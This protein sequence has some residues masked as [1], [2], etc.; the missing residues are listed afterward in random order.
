M[1][2]ATGPLRRIRSAMLVLSI[3][4]LSAGRLAAAPVDLRDPTSRRIQVEFEISPPDQPGRLN[5]FWSPVRV[6]YLRT[7]PERRTVEIRIPAVEIEAHLRSTGTDAVPG[8]FSDFRWVLD[9]ETGEVVRAT[10]S[11][12]IREHLVLGPIRSSALVDIFVDMTTRTDSGYRPARGLLGRETHLHCVPSR[13]SDRCTAV[14]PIPYDPTDGYV[15]AV[16]SLLVATPIIRVRAFSP[17]GEARFSEGPNARRT[18]NPP[19]T[20]PSEETSIRI[21]SGISGGVQ[22]K[23]LCSEEFSGPCPAHLGGES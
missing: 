4:W 6:A 20:K 7:D 13:D 16:G 1:D 15:N 8:T 9:R 14:V 2:V 5:G 12:R 11:G 10:L 18:A 3:G 17:L 22:P 23:A 19:P 21:S